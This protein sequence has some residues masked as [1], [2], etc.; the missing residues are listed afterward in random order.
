M[1]K[2]VR[3]GR[4]GKPEIGEVRASRKRDEVRHEIRQRRSIFRY[5][6]LGVRDRGRSNEKESQRPVPH[7]RYDRLS[8]RSVQKAVSAAMTERSFANVRVSSDGR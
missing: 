6:L 7:T 3:F 5:R 1:R 4:K 8:R 2:P